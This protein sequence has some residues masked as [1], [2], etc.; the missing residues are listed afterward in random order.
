MHNLT[1][2]YKEKYDKY[3]KD[4]LTNNEVNKLSNLEFKINKK[5][6]CYDKIEIFKKL[7]DIDWSKYPHCLTMFNSFQYCDENYDLFKYLKNKYNQHKHITN[8]NCQFIILNK[9]QQIFNLFKNSNNMKNFIS[10]NFV[11]YFYI[12]IS[13]LNIED[14]PTYESVIKLISQ[15][16][17]INLL[18]R[19]FH[20]NIIENY[21]KIMTTM[22]IKIN[23]SVECNT[24]FMRILE[25]LTDCAINETYKNNEKAVKYLKNN[26]LYLFTVYF[27]S[28]KNYIYYLDAMEFLE[29]I[30]KNIYDKNTFDMIFNYIHTNEILCYDAVINNLELCELMSDQSKLYFIY[31]KNYWF[32]TTKEQRKPLLYVHIKLTNLLIKDVATYIIQLMVS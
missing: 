10:R 24:N 3:D 1:E 31:Y 12:I 20:N 6:I 2:F 26:I 32:L 4:K 5:I 30:F 11:K 25:K 28:V 18:Q 23:K 29:Q 16:S 15:K 27:N 17:I 8:N 7:I 19:I 9:Q 14:I 22:K 13:L 21:E